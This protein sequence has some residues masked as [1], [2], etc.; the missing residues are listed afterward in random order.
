MVKSKVSKL[1]NETAAVLARRP[2][3]RQSG[4][5]SDREAVMKNWQSWLVTGVFALILAATREASADCASMADACRH[6][7]WCL[8]NTDA[9]NATNRANLQGATRGDVWS[10]ISA[11]TARCQHDLGSAGTFDNDAGSCTPNNWVDLGR[12]ARST[13]CPAP[14]KGGGALPGGGSCETPSGGSCYSTLGFGASCIFNGEGGTV[15]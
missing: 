2:D 14:P 10:E 4:E 1:L 3:W 8:S 9:R 6:I 5:R 15:R 12:P 7:Q 11:W 13:S